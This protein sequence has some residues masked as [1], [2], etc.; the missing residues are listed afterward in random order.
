MQAVLRIKFMSK[1]ANA[2]RAK[3]GTADVKFSLLEPNVVQLVTEDDRGFVFSISPSP[4]SSFHWF[5]MNNLLPMSTLQD[6][7]IVGA[8]LL[9]DDTPYYR[10]DSFHNIEEMLFVYLS[11]VHWKGESSKGPV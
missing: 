9:V 2:T 7:N 8:S 11:A 4:F 1:P 3:A 5:E 6:S 10:V